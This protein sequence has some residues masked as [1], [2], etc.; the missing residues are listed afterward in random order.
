MIN[1]EWNKN[2]NPFILIENAQTV[3]YLLTIQGEWD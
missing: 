1:L 3:V 2:Q